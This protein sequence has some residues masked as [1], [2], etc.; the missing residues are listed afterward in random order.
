MSSNEIQ[1]PEDAQ[2]VQQKR[3]KGGPAGNQHARKHGLWGARA[4]LS[5]W[6]QAAIDKR[7]AVGRTLTEWRAQIV[8]DLGG[9]ENLSA[10]QHTVL[11]IVVRTKLLLDGI[12]GF[13]LER[14]AI[15]NR[16]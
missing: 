12:D 11:D 6:G 7:S 15:V 14:G 13:I 4:A 16:R 10:Q 3:A 1:Q 5:E 9:S 8:T 2:P